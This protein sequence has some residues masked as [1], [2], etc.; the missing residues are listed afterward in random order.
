VGGE[1]LS[2]AISFFQ[3]FDG[4]EAGFRARA[5]RVLELLNA[6]E[7]AYVLVTSPRRDAIEEAEFFARRLG[8][9][10]LEVAAL[11]VN[12]MHPA[13]GDGSSAAATTARE[14]VARHAGTKAGPLWDN[15]ADL[16][17]L[18]AGEEGQIGGLAGR[19][20]PAPVARVPV[21]HSDVHDLNGL[22]EIC[23]HLFA[24]ER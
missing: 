5:E 16:R 9:G 11:I 6:R 13:F 15:L 21:L 24:G 1:V 17:A 19:V 23:T 18:A 20:A 2:D 10:G 22:T 14:E 12:R 4:M 7:T 8:E 3:A